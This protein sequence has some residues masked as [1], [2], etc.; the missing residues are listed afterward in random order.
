M[1]IYLI[2]RQFTKIPI[3]SILLGI[4]AI[5]GIARDQDQKDLDPDIQ[6]YV[7]P[8]KQPWIDGICTAPGIVRQVRPFDLY[9]VVNI[10][11][12]TS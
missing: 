1:I 10:S 3:L 7:I 12:L 2:T 11:I 8:G 4:N 5:S 6:D 9:I